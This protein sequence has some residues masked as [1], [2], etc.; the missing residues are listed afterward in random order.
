MCTQSPGKLKSRGNGKQ[1]LEQARAAA[2]SSSVKALSVNFT[3]KCVLGRE[4]NFE[5]NDAATPARSSSSLLLPDSLF[6][7]SKKSEGTQIFSET[8]A[9][10]IRLAQNVLL[11]Q[12]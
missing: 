5:A 1:E 3:M 11:P 2:E 9:R 7:P 10:I 8:L 12:K 4:M 6:T